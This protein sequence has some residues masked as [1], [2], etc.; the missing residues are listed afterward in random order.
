M[1]ALRNPWFSLLV[2]VSYSPQYSILGKPLRGILAVCN[3]SASLILVRRTQ[4]SSSPH[5]PSHPVKK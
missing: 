1:Y 2:L 5:A 4:A 3:P